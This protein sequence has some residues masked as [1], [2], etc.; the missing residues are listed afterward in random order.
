M[1]TFDNKKKCVFC[2]TFHPKKSLFTNITAI[3]CLAH[4]ISVLQILA[5]H[6]TFTFYWHHLWTLKGGHLRYVWLHLRNKF[7]QSFYEFQINDLK[8]VDKTQKAQK[9][10]HRRTKR[11]RN[12]DNLQTSEKRTNMEPPSLRCLLCDAFIFFWEGGE[13]RSPLMRCLWMEG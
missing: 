5:N 7:P 4:N 1:A 6:I 2:Y 9:V 13:Q 11:V 12:Q 8:T 10:C 3:P